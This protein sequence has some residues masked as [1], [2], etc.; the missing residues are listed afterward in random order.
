MCSRPLQA[1]NTE[2]VRN[3]GVDPHCFIWKRPSVRTNRLRE[4]LRLSPSTPPFC[5]KLT[6]WGHLCCCSSGCK[7][8]K[9]DMGFPSTV[10]T[11]QNRHCLKPPQKGKCKQNCASSQIHNALWKSYAQQHNATIAV[12]AELCKKRRVVSAT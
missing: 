4:S 7:H 9:S 5:L 2:P 6:L 10:D 3:M 8:R 12:P 11:P 1:R